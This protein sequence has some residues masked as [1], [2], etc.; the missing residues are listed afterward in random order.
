MKRL[1]VC[2][3]STH[4]YPHIGGAEKQIERLSS[5]LVDH[6]IETIVVTK[7]VPDS[8]RYEKHKGVEIYRVPTL[9]GKI[10]AAISFIIMALWTLFQQRHKYSIIHS[11]QVFSPTTIGLIASWLFGR[12]LVVNLH[13]GGQMGDIHKLLRNK[14][15]GERRVQL[16]NRNADAFIAISEEIYQELVATGT[17]Q[18]K[19]HKVYNAVDPDEFYPV[20]ADQKRV[21]RDQLQIP[22]DIP[23]VIF[24]GRLEE[25]K[26][27]PIL[28]EAIA[29]T[30][31]DLHLIIIGSGTLEQNISDMIQADDSLRDKVSMLG[32]KYNIAEYLQASDIWVLP[33]YTEGLPVS[34]LEAMSVAMPIIIT[35]VGAIPEIIIDKQNGFIIPVGD[36]DSL[37]QTIDHI[38]DQPQLAKQVGQKARALVLDNYSV[39]QIGRNHL[40]LYESVDTNK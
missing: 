38:I 23:I 27:V 34:M 30:K 5:W 16:M 26:G 13:R 8:P 40:R 15:I 35:P 18:A 22:Q 1:G 33:S 12:K 11:H 7:S 9:P 28:V 29:K 31:E 19:I 3:I 37:S 36:S 32:R 39:E 10:P 4:Y 17:D 24:V 6:D 2:M 14:S 25:E 21:L 20:E